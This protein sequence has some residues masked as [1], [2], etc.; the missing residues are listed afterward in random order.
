MP[1]FKIIIM[2]PG[3]G[4]REPKILLWAL[5]RW[6]KCCFVVVITQRARPCRQ[7]PLLQRGMD[8]VPM[9]HGCLRGLCLGCAVIHKGANEFP[10]TLY[11]K[12]Q[13]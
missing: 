5:V 2:K 10:L 1:P 12:E 8:V 6:L 13:P 4:S 7:M 3:S 11:P 9:G